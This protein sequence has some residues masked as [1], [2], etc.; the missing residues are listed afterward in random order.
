MMALNISAI[1]IPFRL[2]EIM[3]NMD[4]RKTYDVIKC[5]YFHYFKVLNLIKLKQD[6]NKNPS[7]F[8]QILNS[9]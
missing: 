5:M 4:A 3:L 6:R 9:L 2:S 8:T 7:F 1:N